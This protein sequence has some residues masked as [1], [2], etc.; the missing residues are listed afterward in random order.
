[1]AGGIDNKHNFSAEY[2]RTLNRNAA[3]DSADAVV[4]NPAGVVRMDDG[5]Y[6]NLSGQYAFKKYTNTVDGVE[7]QSDEG[8]FVPS[9]FALWTKD[10]WAAYGAFTI[11]AGGG[12]VDF[13]DGSAT[14][15]AIAEGM[16]DSFNIVSNA[17]LA[18]N[19]LTPY[20]PYDTIR[21]MDIEAESFYYGF[22]L[23]GAF[24]IND[25]FSVSLG[26]RYIDA[27]KID[28]KGSVT[29]GASAGTGPLGSFSDV[30]A[31]VEY[32]DTATGWGG[33]IGLD[34]APCE[35]S[36]IAI[37]YESAVALE[38]ETEQKR[39]TLEAMDPTGVGLVVDG[40][41]YDRDLPA[42]LGFGA[43]YQFTPELKVDAN[44]T[45]YFNSSADWDGAE[46]LVDDGYDVGISFEY[47][48]LPQLIGSV[49]YMWT[50]TGIDA[51]YMTPE[52]PELDAHSIAGGLKWVAMPALDVNLG[53]LKTFYQDDTTTWGVKYEKDVIIV[54][55]GVQY[56]FW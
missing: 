40:A 50:E 26:G 51:D 6:G 10:R 18:A 46:D 19:M 28:A 21:D 43:S 2:I 48:F 12:S 5:F 13:K 11:P 16:I 38:F 36:N 52:S 9:L 20:S 8:D 14:T 42:L 15:V 55:L 33:V 35:R 44:L 53:V 56:K 24:A 32:E 30:T 41:K 1:M 25:M 45:W 47:A 49:G 22:T 3:T 23:G 29:V 31:D 34:V 4:Y 37:R 54:A 7:L 39:D 27:K 17:L